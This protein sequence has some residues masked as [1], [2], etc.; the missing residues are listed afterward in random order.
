MAIRQFGRK[1][2]KNTVSQAQIFY[3]STAFIPERFENAVLKHIINT[4]TATTVPNP[5]YPL[6]LGIQGPYGY[7][8]TFMVKEVCKKYGIHLVSVSSSELS[9]EM[10]GDS[11]KS[12]KRQYEL[13]CYE[14]ERRKTCGALMIDD[15]HLTIAT[16]DNVGKTV[17]S[18]LLASYL[19]NICDNP[20]VT[21][22]RVP[23]IMTGNNYRR[24]YPALIRDGR[25]DIL[26]WDPTID[27]IR[28][29]VTQ[30]FLSKF[31]GID[32]QTIARMLDIYADMNIAFFEQVS[33]DLV[34]TNYIHTIDAFKACK[35]PM[36][37]AELTEY[38]RASLV[39]RELSDEALLEACRIRKETLLI[40][41]ESS[42]NSASIH[43]G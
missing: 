14:I 7:G 27:D 34:G 43:R 22:V 25:M 39:P 16:A 18:N 41:Y 28:P 21:S 2:K 4:N 32:G 1:N 11:K 37:L 6:L 3:Q 17:N 10:E 24:V 13:I 42:A 19:M 26:T 15:F 23:I 33:Q 36:P 29:I 38:V 9:G 12:L 40:D 31:T 5:R 30:I 8:K 20:D 35:G